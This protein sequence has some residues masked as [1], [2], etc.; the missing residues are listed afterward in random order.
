MS[1]PAVSEPPQSVEVIPL[2]EYVQAP[3]GTYAKF[4]ESLPEGRDNTYFGTH[5]TKHN[6][7]VSK[8]FEE[9]LYIIL[10]VKEGRAFIPM[11]E[12]V[13][14]LD[15]AD[16]IYQLGSFYFDTN[17]KREDADKVDVDLD[18]VL[19]QANIAMKVPKEY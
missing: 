19:P 1:M 6:L 18:K 13:F 8:W 12:T 2:E 17:K 5:R 14:K 10:R 11:T 15:Q 16:R 7:F 4:S 9:R 3:I